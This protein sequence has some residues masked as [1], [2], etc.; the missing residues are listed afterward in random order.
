MNIIYL[1]I[2]LFIYLFI[3]L[4]FIYI[5]INLLSLSIVIIIIFITFAIRSYSKNWCAIGRTAT[6]KPAVESCGSATAET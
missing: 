6:S 4:S 1:L 2:Y 5:F 3:Y